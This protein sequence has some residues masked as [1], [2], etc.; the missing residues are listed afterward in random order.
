MVF[1]LRQKYGSVFTVRLGCYVSVFVS[2]PEGA[3]EVLM[4]KSKDFAGRPP[5]KSVSKDAL[6]GKIV[7][8]AN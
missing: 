4:T 8:D 2:S 5:L 3:R 6:C 1:S 7:I